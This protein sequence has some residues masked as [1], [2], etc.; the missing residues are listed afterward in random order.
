MIPARAPDFWW[1][2]PGWQALLLSPLAYAYGAAARWR[3]INGERAEAGLPVLC[4]GNFT[5]GG[6]G[7]TPTALA[8]GRAALTMGLRP[9]FLSRGHGGALRGPLLVDLARHH[10]GDVGDEPM[11][12]ARLAPTAIAVDRKLG[13]E[14]LRCEADCDLVIM[15]DGFQSQRLSF[16]HVLLVVDAGRGLGNARVVPAGPLRAPLVDQISHADAVLVIG[17][18]SAGET[19]IRSAAKGGRPVYAAHLRP[20]HADNFAGRRCLAFAG[21]ADPGKFY[22]SLEG[23]GADLVETRDFPDHHVFTAAELQGLC[24]AAEQQALQLVTT[25]KDAVRLKAGGAL[26]E[27]FADRIAVLDVDLVFAPSGVPEG[28]IRET[29]DAFRTRPA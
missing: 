16:D 14:L 13:A 4:I 12:L 17:E 11:L 23:L 10:A 28:I 25:R 20:R 18:G 15:D 19:A 8:L 26:V 6:G 24:D 2:R 7:K 21:I 3:L 5:V 27:A 9:G 22:R 29:L 1:T